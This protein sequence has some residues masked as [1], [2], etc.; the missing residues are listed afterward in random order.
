MK[1]SWLFTAI[2]FLALIIPISMSFYKDYQVFSKGHIVDV[3]ITR[4]PQTI[5]A[6]GSV[7]MRFKMNEKIYDKRVGASTS[8]FYRVG[9]K[10]KLRYLAGY[11]SNFLFP[12]E[13]PTYNGIVVILIFLIGAI[14]SFYYAFRNQDHPLEQ[15]IR[16]RFRTR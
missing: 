2:L 8:R 12:S 13:T 4:I 14:F 6:K 9:D 15:A 16:K 1:V 10:I 7:F 5:G 11:E 3:V